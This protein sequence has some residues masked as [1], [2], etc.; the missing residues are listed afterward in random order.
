[1]ISFEPFRKMMKE[2]KISTYY[3]RTK[4]GQYSLD[5]KT[6]KRMFDDMPV[7]TTTLDSLCNALQCDLADLVKFVPD[8]TKQTDDEP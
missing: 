3:L 1:M 8:C 2:R 4:C 7:S 5:S 6:I